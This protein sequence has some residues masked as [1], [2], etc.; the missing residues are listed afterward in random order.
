[1]DIIGDRKYVEIPGGTTYELPPLLVKTAPDVKRL[2]RV[3]DMARGYR[4]V[5][6]S[7]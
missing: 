5:F 7:F 3:V 1:M 2:D 6:S 4:S